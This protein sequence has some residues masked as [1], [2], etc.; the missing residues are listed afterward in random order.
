MKGVLGMGLSN[1]LRERREQ[2]GL[3]QGEVASLLGITPGAVGN[4]ENGV[5]TPKADILFKVFDALKC[6]ANYL[7]QDEMKNLTA[8]DSATPDEM[9]KIIKKYRKLDT[10][11]KEMVDFTLLKEWERSLAEA[12]KSNVVPM[13]LKEDTTYYVNAA[14]PIEGASE[15]DKQFD[16]DIMDDGNF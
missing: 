10:H 2:L 6:D 11:G 3:T 9:E 16:E 8:E 14:H 4:Y 7:F 13:A 15:E 5:S 12:E 1:R